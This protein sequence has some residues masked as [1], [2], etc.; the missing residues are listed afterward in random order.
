MT[1]QEVLERFCSLSALVAQQAFN[2]EKPADCFCGAKKEGEGWEFSE[3]VIALIESAVK[4][5]IAKQQG[6]DW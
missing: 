1:K 2:W 3:D 6:Q 5:S 4:C